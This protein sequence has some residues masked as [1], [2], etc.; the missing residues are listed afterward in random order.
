M[1]QE[2]E[3]NGSPQFVGITQ[4][5]II[6]ARREA[7]R[8]VD[9]AVSKIGPTHDATWMQAQLLAASIDGLLIGQRDIVERLDRLTDAVALLVERLPVPSAEGGGGVE[10][11]GGIKPDPETK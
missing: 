3:K 6:E 4:A 5:R 10:G 2:E 1:K 9:L 11:G 7:K 8:R